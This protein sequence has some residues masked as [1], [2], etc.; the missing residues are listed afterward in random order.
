ML[1]HRGARLA[2]GVAALIAGLAIPATAGARSA[3]PPAAPVVESVP[4]FPSPGG[5]PVA[6]QAWAGLSGETPLLLDRVTGRYRPVPYVSIR[7][8][9]DG[10]RVAVEKDDGRIGIA[11]RQQLL[12][13]GDRA[14]RWTALPAAGMEWSPDGRALLTT[15]VDKERRRQTAH[16]LDVR[17]G[18]VRDTLLPPWTSGAVGWAADSRRYLVMAEPADPAA[19][20]GPLRY[21]DPDGTA[22]PALGVEGR[23]WGAD[24]YSP[25]RRLVIVEPSRPELTPT[26]AQVL[27][28]RTGRVLAVVDAELPLLGWHDEWQVV[29]VAPAPEGTPTVLEVLDVR[30]GRVSERIRAGGLPAGSLLQLGSTAC[31]APAAVRRGF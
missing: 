8:A 28:L 26:P 29:R 12:R 14:V 24:A 9:P 6:I 22:G 23:V 25:S 15:T 2:A 27:D 1:K 7:L 18:R 30:T 31:L 21:V 4:T 13:H 10:L 5:G 20:N 17:T 19:T 16:R 3:P 11:D